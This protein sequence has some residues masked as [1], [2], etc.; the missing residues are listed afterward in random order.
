MVN[1]LRDDGHW[2]AGVIE[3]RV[4]DRTDAGIAMPADHDQIGASS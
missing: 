2:S 1:L 4:L 3:Q